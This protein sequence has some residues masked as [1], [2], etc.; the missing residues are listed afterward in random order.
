MSRILVA[1]ALVTATP[2][3]AGRP[4]VVE[5]QRQDWVDWLLQDGDRRFQQ[6]QLLAAVGAGAVLFGAGVSLGDV[7][8]N[9]R[10]PD[11]VRPGTIVAMA[12]GPLLLAGLPT[13]AAGA[14]RMRKAMRMEGVVVPNVPLVGA[15]S[16]LGTGLVLVPCATL[17]WTVPPTALLFAAGMTGMGT[18]ALATAQYR[19]NCAADFPRPW[20]F[21]V[22]M[23]QGAGVGFSGRW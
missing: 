3:F 5:A 15:W 16:M 10:T 18:Y 19:L 4:M 17:F 22:P 12:G 9:G 2:S 7:I 21:P 20:V 1:L 11:G 8:E 23:S 6:G 13:M 14:G